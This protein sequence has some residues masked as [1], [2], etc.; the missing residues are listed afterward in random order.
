MV[1]IFRFR[2]SYKHACGCS[3]EDTCQEH[4]GAW[5]NKMREDNI[6]SAKSELDPVNSISISGMLTSQWKV[7]P[8]W[9]PMEANFG[10]QFQSP[11]RACTS[12]LVSHA[13][14]YIFWRVFFGNTHKTCLQKIEMSLRISNIFRQ[15]QTELQVI[16]FHEN[17][18]PNIRE[19]WWKALI[20]SPFVTVSLPS[21][22]NSRQFLGHTAITNPFKHSIM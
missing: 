20:A 5:I 16:C 4:G 15:S 9:P 1:K 7:K 13:T 2:F 21:L 11:T 12:V 18:L 10:R 17:I 8:R 3:P 6:K 22:D 19:T 14:F